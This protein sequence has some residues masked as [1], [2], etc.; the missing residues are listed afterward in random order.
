MKRKHKEKKEK[1]LTP[2]EEVSLIERKLGYSTFEREADSFDWIDLHD[3]DFNEALGD[4]ENGIRCGSMIELFG[5]ESHGKTLVATIIASIAQQDDPK[6]T[7]VAKEDL[8]L[9][10]NDKFNEKMG[11]NLDKFYLFK[12]KIAASLKAIKRLDSIKAQIEKASSKTRIKELT[13]KLTKTTLKAEK[14]VESAEMVCTKVEQ[15][16]KYKRSQDPKA[17]IIL[18]V[19]S[20]TGMLVSEESDAG[21]TDQN[22]RTNVSLASFLSDLCRRW[23]SFA[24]NYN[25][26]IIFI[27]QLRVAPGVMF[28]N[29]EYTPGGKA[30]KFYCSVRDKISR[31]KGGRITKHGK[32]IGI[33]IKLANVKNKVGG[34]EGHKCGLRVDI[35]KG[36]WK[37]MSTKDLESESRREKHG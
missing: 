3:K 31:V 35:R 1:K 10:N 29:P 4:R 33:R 25:T 27:N 36:K 14:F 15:W 26:T 19:D 32:V 8:E 23:V 24:D 28:G 12:P 7:Y 37:V 17:R 13:D 6:H 20:V 9:S 21:L 34:A 2:A 30:L 18:I 5:W 22:M 11:L 16:I